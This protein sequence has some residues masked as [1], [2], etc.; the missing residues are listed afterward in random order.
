MSS[1]EERDDGD[2]LQGRYSDI[3]TVLGTL[4]TLESIVISINSIPSVDSVVVV[5]SNVLV[6]VSLKAMFPVLLVYILFTASRD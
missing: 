3:L 6:E 5:E 1:T 4:A 2:V